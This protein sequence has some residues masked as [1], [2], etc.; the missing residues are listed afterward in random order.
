MTALQNPIPQDIK[1]E[2]DRLWNAITDHNVDFVIR[3]LDQF[4]ENP[5]KVKLESKDKNVLSDAQRWISRLR[6]HL[7]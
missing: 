7:H 4:N 3:I 1:T 2:A 5:Q 6:V